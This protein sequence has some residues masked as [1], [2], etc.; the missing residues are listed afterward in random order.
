MNELARCPLCGKEVE[1]FMIPHYHKS[2][3]IL[4]Q[5]VISCRCGLTLEARISPTAYKHD[6]LVQE[7]IDKW[8]H[9]S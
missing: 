4:E 3:K 2:A 7:F 9:R 8:N 1:H 5:H 6:A